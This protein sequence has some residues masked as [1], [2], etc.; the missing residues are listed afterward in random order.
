[1]EP[2][3]AYFFA[4]NQD[5]NNVAVLKV[6]AKTGHLT[7]TGQQLEMSQPGSVLLVKAAQ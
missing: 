5:S 6:G 7:P 3:G 1:M 2:T 4:S